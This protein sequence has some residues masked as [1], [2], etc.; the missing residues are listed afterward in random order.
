MSCCVSGRELVAR[1]YQRDVHYA[2]E[3]DETDVV[4]QLTGDRFPGT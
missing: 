4:P 2:A 3:W 1:G